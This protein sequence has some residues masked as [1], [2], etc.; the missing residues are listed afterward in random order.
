[1]S[2][3]IIYNQHSHYWEG[4]FTIFYGLILSPYLEFLLEDVFF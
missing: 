3:F 4:L 2:F 1:M